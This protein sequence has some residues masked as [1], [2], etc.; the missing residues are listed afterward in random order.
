MF[1]LGRKSLMLVAVPAVV[2]A[3]AIHGVD[4]DLRGIADEFASHGYI[5]A[6]P[7]FTAL[8]VV[9]NGA[10]ELMVDVFGDKGRHART[11]IGVAGL[12]LD[13]KILLV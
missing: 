7:G 10:S 11:T 4:N 3:S 1:Q 6:A 13:E 12:P 9:M 8:P 2:L 5:A